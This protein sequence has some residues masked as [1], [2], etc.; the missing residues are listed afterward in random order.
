L[1]NLQEHIAAE[2][3]ASMCGKVFRVLCEEPTPN[4]SGNL[5][6]RTQGNVIIE[7]PAPMQYI[8]QFVSVKVTQAQTWKLKGE[9]VGG[10]VTAR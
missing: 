2:R 10:S 1:T 8:G 7:F 4:N 3:T 9:L 6:G 5:I